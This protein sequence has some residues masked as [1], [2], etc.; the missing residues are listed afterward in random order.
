MSEF[1]PN[2]DGLPEEFEIS[3]EAMDRLLIDL[4]EVMSEN[5]TYDDVVGAQILSDFIR[6]P[7][8][9]DDEES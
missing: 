6:D 8:T 3:P 1:Q 4:V 2:G 5:G 9:S 7:D